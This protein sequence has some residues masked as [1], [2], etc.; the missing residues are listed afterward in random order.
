[1]AKSEGKR[2]PP[3]GGSSS[4]KSTAVPKTVDADDGLTPYV[5]VIIAIVLVLLTLVYFFTK[6]AKK[7]RS[8]L[9]V[10]ACESGKTELFARIVG[11]PVVQTVTSLVPNEL[12]YTPKNG[13]AELV[14]KDLPGHDRVRIK[15]WDSNKVASRGIV[16]VVDA[17]GGNKGI[18]D[19]ADVI[20]QVLT[21]SSVLSTR[22]AILIFANKQDLP[23][24]KG[25]KVI[26]NQLEKE[27]TTLRMTKSASLQSTRGKDSGSKVLGRSEEDFDF[28][29]MTQLQ[30]DFAEGCAIKEENQLSAVFSWLDKIA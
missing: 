27:L 14:I 15:F 19:A 18:R 1:M 3:P 24:A 28:D 9:L 30:I 8:V 17:A 13:K 26:R 22:P 7:G 29:H 5:P 16:C 4:A 6:K 23:M 11:G 25:S 21:D 12:E 20:Y 10:G 2:S